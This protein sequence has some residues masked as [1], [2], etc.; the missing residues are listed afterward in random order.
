MTAPTVAR[1]PADAS[2]EL[3]RKLH[4]EAAWNVPLGERR[5]CPLHLNWRDLCAQL[6]ET[7]ERP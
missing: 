3:L 1:I 7:E 6:H 2:D 4:V 5:T